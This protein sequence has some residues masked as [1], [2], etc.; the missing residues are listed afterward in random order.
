MHKVNHRIT[1]FSRLVKDFKRLSNKH[2]AN[3]IDTLIQECG[4]EQKWR[5]QQKLPELLL[6]DFLKDLPAELLDKVLSYLDAPNL[7]TC[8]KVSRVW[9]ERLTPN[10]HLWR[11]IILI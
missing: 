1:S 6:R 2:Q 5:L 7:L 8:L 4:S 10:V 3:V 9:N 11:V